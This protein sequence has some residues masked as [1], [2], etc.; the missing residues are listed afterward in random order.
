LATYRNLLETTVSSIGLE[1][2]GNGEPVTGVSTPL[3]VLIEYTEILLEP[4]LATNRKFPLEF[5]AKAVGSVPAVVREEDSVR[6]PEL[7]SML[8]REMSPPA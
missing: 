6:A 7:E 5:M 4:L 3:V 1:L 2:V 8:N